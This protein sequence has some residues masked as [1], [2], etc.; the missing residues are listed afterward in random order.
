M[1]FKNYTYCFLLC[2]KHAVLSGVNATQTFH[3]HFKILKYINIIRLILV[4]E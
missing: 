2:D 4:L 3:M 1:F